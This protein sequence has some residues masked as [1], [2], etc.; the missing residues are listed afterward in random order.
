MRKFIPLLALT[1]ISVVGVAQKKIAVG[2]T[3]NFSFATKGLGTNDVGLG[4]TVYSN[5]LA[6]DRLQLRVE[7]GLDQFIGNKLLAVDL[8]GNTYDGS[9]ALFHAR[10]GP[11][12]FIADNISLGALYG[13]LRYNYFGDQVSTGQFKFLFNAHLGKKKKGVFSLY[14]A[15]TSRTTNVAFWGVSLGYRFL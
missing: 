15:R 10:F 2:G 9:P 11:E 6:D 14:H 3:A 12:L 13:L 5:F 4:F 8:S 7:T 1:F